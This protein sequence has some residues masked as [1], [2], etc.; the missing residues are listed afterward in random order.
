MP[1]IVQFGAPEARDTAIVGG[2]GSNLGQLAQAEFPV[3]PGFCVTTEAYSAFLAESGL[4]RRIPEALSGVDY[5]DAGDLEA[6]TAKIRDMIAHAAMPEGLERDLRAA[7]GEIG[8]SEYVAVRSSGTAED[9]AEASFAGLHDTLLD[10]RG[11]DALVEAVRRCWA[12]LWTARATS[13]RHSKGWD[14]SEALLAVVVQRM[15]PSEVSG[16]MFTANPLTTATEELMINSSWGLGEAVVSG[17]VT[18]DTYIVKADDLH[19]RDR[20]LGDKEVRIRRDAASSHGTITEDTDGSDRG[21]LTLS[22][23][24]AAELAELGLRI[25]EH[26]QGFP[27]DIEWALEGGAF[28]LLQ[29]RPITGVE[30]SWDDDL[31]F[32]QSYP[33]VD[34]RVWTRA[35][36]DENWTGAI[37]PLMY[38][39]RAPSWVA[40]HVPA[41]ELW[42]FPDLE[43]TRFWKFHKGTAY[44]NC[45]LGRGIV[46]RTV[47]PGQR[48]GMMALI[49]KPWRAEV[50]ATPFNWLDYIKMYARIEALRPQMNKGFKILYGKWREKYS[51]EGRGIPPAELVRL[52]DRELK[53]YVDGMIEMEDEYNRDL[54]SW[55]F[56][57]F[58]DTLNWLAV[59]L[60]KWYDS[61]DPMAF[62]NLLTGTPERTETMKMNH[63]LWELS[64]RIRHSDELTTAFKEHTDRDFFDACQHSLDGRAFLES[65]GEFL[66]AYGHRGHEDRDIY[67]QR[68]VEDPSIDYRALAS[69]LN[70]AESIDPEVKEREVNRQREEF[71]DKVIDTIRR[72][73][74]GAVKA[75]IF[76]LVYN[77]AIH[78]LMARDNERNGI[79]FA[80]MSIRQGF[81][82]VGRRLASRGVLASEEDLWFVGK[83][84]LY[85]LLDGAETVTPLLRAKI[86]ARR[87]DFVRMLEREVVPPPYLQNRQ[88]LDLDADTDTGDGVLRGIGTARG[89]VTA[90]ARV[91]K[92]LDEV[93]KVEEGEILVVNATDPGWTPVFHIISGIVLETGGIL[94]HGSCLAREY[95]LPAVQLPSAMQRIPDGATV[96]LNGDAGSVTVEET[97]EIGAAA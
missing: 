72:G 75:E 31:D 45:D 47:P 9:Q 4:D 94:A 62:Q 2:K 14:H 19:V 6:R 64:E 28:Y 1:T 24:Q 34:D 5:S 55:F 91:V 26:Y 36:A 67:F 37:S 39:W 10:I 20:T 56:I 76:K 50:N 38:S 81:K 57:C 58:R 95:G 15:V 52:S 87:R 53:R 96:T 93:G 44:F 69:M 61:S 13:Y 97:A 66:H 49:P 35:M 17:I 79:D 33:D 3:P 12:S 84:V 92:K 68:R 88:G 42:G 73:P 21:R 30:L 90:T 18:P 74:L 51:T 71:A 23:A 46:E 16:V 54:W 8:E 27:Q 85:R 40:G 32:W 65:Y 70:T 89:T 11:A 83:D 41:A 60:A 82:E 63:W 48:Q 77:Q 25:Q 7:Y 86:D 78:F 22:D 59:L 29:S 80:T 43:K